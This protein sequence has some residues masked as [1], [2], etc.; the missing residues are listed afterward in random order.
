MAEGPFVRIIP[1][2]LFSFSVMPLLWLF[3]LNAM[4][5]ASSASKISGLIRS[6][7]GE[8]P[9]IL[10]IP[11][12]TLKIGEQRVTQ[13]REFRK[14]DAHYRTIKLEFDSWEAGSWTALGMWEAGEEGRAGPLAVSGEGN[15]KCLRPVPMNSLPNSIYDSDLCLSKVRNYYL[16]WLFVQT[17]SYEIWMPK[18]RH[19]ESLCVVL[20]PWLDYNWP[21][22]KWP[23]CHS[24]MLHSKKEQLRLS[25]GNILIL[26]PFA[27]HVLYAR[28]SPFDSA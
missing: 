22:T 24:P 9:S 27:K 4:N 10:K 7:S 17:G 16:V 6:Y 18:V 15:M 12:E 2:W 25:W 13:G 21:F 14:S 1:G 5:I 19:S 20:S 3:L 26:L 28:S 11:R 23:L 8:S